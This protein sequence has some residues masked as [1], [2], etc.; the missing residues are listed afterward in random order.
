MDTVAG[1]EV[2]GVVL[3]CTLSGELVGVRVDE[4]SEVIEGPAVVVELAEVCLELFIEG[5]AVVVVVVAVV[6]S[7]EKG[8]NFRK[9]CLFLLV[10]VREPSMLTK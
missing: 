4:A 1:T 10:M 8:T 3:I 6:V 2:L 9:N 7:G 5:L